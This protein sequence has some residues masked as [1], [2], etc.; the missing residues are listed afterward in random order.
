ML[1]KNWMSKD[2][3]TVNANAPI[4][5]AIKLL[6]HHDIGRLP[7]MQKDKMVG[8]VTDRDLKS[9]S[10]SDAVPFEV[11]EL[12]YLLSKIKIEEVMSKNPI[13]VPPDYTV[14]ETADVFLENKISSTPVVDDQDQLVGIITQKDLFKALISLTGKRNKGIEFAFKVEDRPGSIKALTDIIRNY[15]GRLMSI[16]SFNENVQEGYRN[17]YIEVCRI[18]REKVS[19]LKKKLREKGT[20]LYFVDKWQN[21]R[22]IYKK[23]IPNS[24]WFSPLS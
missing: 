23:R 13:T 18:D 3:I 9:A 24:I 16:L 1:V 15:K 6:K 12:L 14:E 19:Q 21:E 17:V 22:E 8:I 10:A 11:H 4:I 5:D 2:V 20:M 7:V